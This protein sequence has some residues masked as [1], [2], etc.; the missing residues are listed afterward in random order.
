MEEELR[1]FYVNIK[2]KQ[3]KVVGTPQFEPYV[4]NK[5]KIEL[6]H[7]IDNFDLDTTKIY[8]ELQ[9]LST[10]FVEKLIAFNRKLNIQTDVVGNLA[11]SGNWFHNLKEDLSKS[12]SILKIRSLKKTN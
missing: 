5:Y 2:P 4:L 8:L 3:V 6:N 1:N 9:F 7:F 11:K 10:K 12:K